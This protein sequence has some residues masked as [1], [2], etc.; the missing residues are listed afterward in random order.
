M[1]IKKSYLKQM[2]LLSWNFSFKKP[3]LSSW[4]SCSIDEW[5]WVLESSPTHI[6][7]KRET[8]FPR[9]QL[10][11]SGCVTFSCLCCHFPTLFLTVL[12][13]LWL[14]GGNRIV[15]SN[16]LARFLCHRLNVLTYSCDFIT[17][18]LWSIMIVFHSVTEMWG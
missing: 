4:K 16:K 2:Y 14:L 7:G 1:T 5:S 6:E 3:E 11:V 13:L 10:C 9:H 17:L 18:W 8:C 15:G 12:R